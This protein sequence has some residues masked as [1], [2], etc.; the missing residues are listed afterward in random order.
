MEVISL[1]LEKRSI[2]ATS[3]IDS[4]GIAITFIDSEKEMGEMLEQLGMAKVVNVDFEGIELGRDG[5]LCLGQFHVANSELVYV[6]DFAKEGFDPFHCGLKQIMES[7]SILKVFFDP[8]ADSDCIYAHYKVVMKNVLCLQASEVAY[9]RANGYRV[10]YV[11]GLKRTL[12]EHIQ[13]K[14]KRA[15]N[16]IKER[17]FQLFNPITGSLQVFKSRPLETAI[18]HYAAVDVFYFDQLKVRLFDSLTNSRQTWVLK[19][20][21]KRV[22][23]CFSTTYCSKNRE[24]AIAP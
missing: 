15:M 4:L 13:I 16:E 1:Q 10:R 24:N 11:I 14:N 22:N 12:D 8:R 21:E 20:S 5:E 23:V 7:S 18:L 2:S 19:E 9:R 17:G 6:V 3:N